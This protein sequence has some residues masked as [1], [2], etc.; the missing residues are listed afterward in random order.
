MTTI[1]AVAHPKSTFWNI[2]YIIAGF[3][4]MTLSQSFM[5]LASGAAVVLLGGASGWYH[6][7]ASKTSQ[8]ADI[9]AIYGVFFIGFAWQLSAN[10]AVAPYNWL[11]LLTA[12]GLTVAVGFTYDD[13]SHAQIGVM[14][15]A[16]IV[17][18]FIRL[19]LVYGFQWLMLAQFVVA[20]SLYLSGLYA[21]RKAEWYPKNSYEYDQLHARWHRR[22]AAA[23]FL[24]FI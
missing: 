11:L 24:T 6:W 23:I 18:L 16:N 10:P 8:R 5:Q 17:A 22:T 15:I 20:V 21:A 14:A 3:A 1:K 19:D 9:L 13:W 4:L 12:V 7:T 2:A